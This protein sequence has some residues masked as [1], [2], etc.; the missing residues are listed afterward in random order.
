MQVNQELIK[1]IRASFVMK[2]TSF[3]S[4]CLDCGIDPSNARKA[5]SGQW[6]GDRAAK[7][8]ALIMKETGI[9]FTPPTDKQPP[10]Q[11]KRQKIIN[12]DGE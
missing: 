3:N 6:K 11:P 10:K 9:S 7:I 8:C 1:Q 5:I 4:F 2:G 12:W